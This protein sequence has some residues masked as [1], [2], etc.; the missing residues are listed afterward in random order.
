[1][2]G[3]GGIGIIEGDREVEIR[4]E[5][6]VG[7]EKL[8]S[9][10]VVAGGD[11]L[12]VGVDGLV[13]DFVIEITAEL[14]GGFGG[15]VGGLGVVGLGGAGEEKIGVGNG[16]ANRVLLEVRE[17]SLEGNGENDGAFV[18]AL[19]VNVD[20]VAVEGADVIGEVAPEA[21][22]F[23]AV[24]AADFDGTFGGDV[25]DTSGSGVTGG[26]DG[27][28]VNR[29][30]VEDDLVLRIKIG[31]QEAVGCEREILTVLAPGVAVNDGEG[32]NLFA[33]IG[34][35]ERIERLRRLNFAIDFV[36]GFGGSLLFG[37]FDFF[38]EEFGS[39]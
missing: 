22:E 33:A 9:D 29:A 23:V 1:M 38:G 30:T 25:G 7:R 37:G 17:G 32:E 26:E 10:F 27:R 20:A 6:G 24:E 3:E 15:V 13:R 18:V 5:F 11:E 39:S 31:A 36:F 4:G 21:G 28:K 34:R 14:T 19:A 12:G 8:G 2:G 16:N 35:E